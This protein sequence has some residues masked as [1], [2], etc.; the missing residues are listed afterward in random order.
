MQTK[1]RKL[2]PILLI[3]LCTLG[4]T[5]F[6]FN[7]QL[8][9][10]EPLSITGIT[11]QNYSDGI[12]YYKNGV[13]VG[14]LN[15]FD[16]L[17]N[18][19]GGNKQYCVNYVTNQ[20]TGNERY[21]VHKLTA[22]TITAPNN[23]ALTVRQFTYLLHK[24]QQR[25]D[26]VTQAALAYLAHQ[27]YETVAPADHYGVNTTSPSDTAKWLANLVQQVSP[28]VQQLAI[29]LVNEAKLRAT[30]TI[31]PG[32]IH[33]TN[34]RHGTI[35]GI[36]AL[37]QNNDFI[38]GKT[39]SITLTGPA[40]FTESK[41][42][43]WQGTTLDK[44]LNL[45]WEATGNGNVQARITF[46]VEKGSLELW[47]PVETVQSVVTLGANIQEDTALSDSLTWEVV[48]DFQPKGISAA[49]KIAQAGT[50]TDTLTVFA[51]PAYGK[52]EWLKDGENFIPVKF[53]A[54]AYHLGE[55][56]PTPSQEVPSNARLLDTIEVTATG[57][58][59]IVATFTD[60]PPGFTTVVWEMQKNKQGKY[61]EYVRQN[62]Q[63]QFALLAETTLQP[64]EF[65]IDSTL[66][67]RD[68]K[69]GTY[70]VDDL[71]ISGLPNNH[72]N[73]AGNSRFSA[74]SS[75]IFQELWFFPYPLEVKEENLA[76]A[77]KI[78][79]TLQI[80]ARN[81]HYP[82]LGS[83]TFKIRYDQHD[84][85]I[86]GTYV[87]ITHFPGD[88]RVKPLRTA[89][90][91]THEQ[92]VIT[93]APALHTTL[94]FDAEKTAPSYGTQTLTDKVCYTNLQTQKTYRLHGE[95]FNPDTQESWNIQGE[96]I[97]TPT[98]PNGCTTVNFS[99]DATKLAGKTVV[100]VET[101]FLEN[102][103]V[104]EHH[105][106]TDLN[107]TLNFLPQPN[108]VTS[109]YE[110]KDG[111]KILTPTTQVNVIDKVCETTGQLRTDTTYTIITDAVLKRNGESVLPQKVTSYFAPRAANDCAEVKISFNAEKLA[112]EEV[113][114][115]ETVMHKDNVVTIHHDLNEKMQTV[116]FT[117]LPPP[118][119]LAKTGAILSGLLGITLG[120]TGLGLALRKYT[121]P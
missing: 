11:A 62:W 23:I 1:K 117:E 97:F 83:Q 7:T 22:P 67:I 96:T 34:Q 47:D 15:F 41:S 27:N 4:I 36:G 100:A 63:D 14:G 35:Q 65:Q 21:E 69:S 66:Q 49:Q 3:T 99:V 5:A 119:T 111:D 87:F 120:L 45:A 33:T 94:L 84:Q 92:Y 32:I 60:L 73:F 101:L 102:K 78:G 42:K 18:R 95:L 2:I 17:D 46:S 54:S 37:N 52:G 12:V 51:D 48:Y 59:D 103:K 81:G 115:F 56:I 79:N 118:P 16:V 80:P 76:Q 39:V 19:T 74:D 86:P 50:F 64:T 109:A 112:G 114:L 28:E 53:T 29:N 107:Q 116:K 43:T 121:K 75:V 30:H 93:P 44:G 13:L 10:S 40:V 6:P 55:E 82:N 24:Y 89:V 68:T 91:D 98:T 58:S 113:V 90:T 110:E 26:P 105:D 8:A 9:A 31:T 70:L 38:A 108:L 61:K 88:E 72:P 77:E 104:A 25:K 106:L 71:F 85:A 20:P 57:P